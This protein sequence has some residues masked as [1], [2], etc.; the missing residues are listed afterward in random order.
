MAGYPRDVVRGG[1]SPGQLGQP[2][3]LRLVCV[4]GSAVWAPTR[5]RLSDTTPPRALRSRARRLVPVAVAVV[6]GGGAGPRARLTVAFANDLS[7]SQFVGGVA[8]PFAG[9]IAGQIGQRGAHWTS[10][11][12]AP[13][14]YARHA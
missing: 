14:T 10:R 7:A 12:V 11:R 2:R 4:P 3:L 6:G 1:A 8:E 9:Q 5:A 13:H